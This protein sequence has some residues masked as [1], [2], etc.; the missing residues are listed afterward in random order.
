MKKSLVVFS[1]ILLVIVLTS[2]N[3]INFEKRLKFFKIEEIEIKNLKV[4]NKKKLKI[5][6][7]NEFYETS[8]LILDKKKIDK[9]FN[10]ND[11]IDYI[12][13]RKVYPSK[14]QIIVYEKE[15]IAIINN[16]QSKFYLT[17][18]GQEIEFFKNPILED[19]PNIF[20]EQ[21]NFLI[22][23]KALIQVNFPTPQIKSFY[24][25]DIGRWDIILKSGKVIKLPSK[26]FITSLK[27]YMELAEKINFEK[28]SIFDYRIKDQLILN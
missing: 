22:I 14:L 11:L 15:T 16:K 24:Y 1:L 18:D 10:N 28:Y 3:P 2:F 19:L 20:G 4:L 25:F 6:F 13:F 27:N 26:N 21:K 12:E 5:Q 9:I 23:Y 17:K 7:L 8:L